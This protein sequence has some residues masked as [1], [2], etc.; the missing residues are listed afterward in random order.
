M[1]QN[2][3]NYF[4]NKSNNDIL[5]NI[6]FIFIFLNNYTTFVDTYLPSMFMNDIYKKNWYNVS[7]YIYQLKNQ[8]KFDKYK[9]LLEQNGINF[10]N[11]D[12]IYEYLIEN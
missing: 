2:P 11:L 5:E 9:I 10:L 6:T 7:I 8:I 12:E 4:F 3:V 1:Y